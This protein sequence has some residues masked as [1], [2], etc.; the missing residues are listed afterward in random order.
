MYKRELL[1]KCLLRRD[2]SP[3]PW[4]KFLK[5]SR[6]INK[7]LN[8]R[9]LIFLEV[10]HQALYSGKV[11]GNR[12]FLFC[13]RL[14]GPYSKPFLSLFLKILAELTDFKSRGIE[15]HKDGESDIESS[16]A[17]ASSSDYP[18]EYREDI[19][20]WSANSWMMYSPQ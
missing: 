9:R 4:V 10:F 15:F 14:V 6:K 12:S 19:C 13:I 20:S 2:F 8:K 11:W 16:R 1:Q 17:V 7:A 5:T 3:P 18:L